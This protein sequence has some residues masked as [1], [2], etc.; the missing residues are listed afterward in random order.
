VRF[1]DLNKGFRDAVAAFQ[2][3]AGPSALLLTSDG[4]HL[5][6][7][8]NALMAGMILKALDVPVPNKVGA[9]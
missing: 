6:D 3:H 2:K 5:N 8:G 1:I 4:V 9:K 7:A